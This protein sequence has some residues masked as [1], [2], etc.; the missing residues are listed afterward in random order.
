M[1]KILMISLL[2]SL[3][4][5]FVACDDNKDEYLSDYSTIVYFRNSG[6]IPLTLYKTGEDTEYQLTVNKSGSDLASVTDVE[7]AVL[8]DAALDAYNAQNGTSYVKLP[9][10]CYQ[11]ADNRLVF[12]SDNL[13]KMAN[14][15]FKTD[16]IYNLPAGTKY[17]LPVSLVNSA[18]SINSEKDKTILIPSVEIPFVYFEQTGFVSNTFTDGGDTQAKFTL[19]VS[20]PMVS[21]W[22]FDC[23][24]GVDESLLE[25]YNKENETNYAILPQSVYSLS[26]DGTVSFVPEENSKD[27]EIT[28]D[29]TKLEYG[30]F[31]LPLRLIDCSKDGFVIDA[32]KNACLYGISYVPDESKLKKVELT[33]DM[34]SSNAVEPSEGLLANLL[35]GD[36]ETY[37]HSAWSVAVEGSH[38][39]QVA[40][41]AE[42]TA[43]NFYY[44]TRSANGSAAPA[45][46]IIEGSL[47][48]VS[49]NKISTLTDGLPT[50]GKETYNSKI[51]VGKPFKI[52]RFSVPENA[53][54]GNFFVW[55]EFGMKVF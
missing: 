4:V 40:L 42:T 9:E 16:L 55:S 43:F 17:V 35:D 21:K 48:G 27:L 28:V 25:E 2:F 7:V 1:K 23:T 41:P 5:G 31:V 20:I 12:G 47:D 32:A 8:D 13:Y 34:L 37:F 19:P 39:L 46:I 53:T 51:M 44:T 15:V 18:D 29:R 36:V 49:F 11:L 14:I 45:K 24:V 52:I 10:N 26:N 6:E 30:N 38:Y 50:G 54:G 33:A 22:T 3:T